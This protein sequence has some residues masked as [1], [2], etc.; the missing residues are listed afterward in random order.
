[1]SL[2]SLGP[3]GRKGRPSLY[4]MALVAG[5]LSLN[6]VFW[7]LAIKAIAFLGLLATL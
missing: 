2:A 1:M 4:R 5:F 7:Y 6:A 3:M